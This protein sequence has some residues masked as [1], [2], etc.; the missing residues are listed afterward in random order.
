MSWDVGPHVGPLCLT[1]Q[2]LAPRHP[3]Y[4]AMRLR[5]GAGV[6]GSSHQALC[7]CVH[8]QCSAHS[9][10][11]APDSRPNSPGCP[12]MT[13]GTYPNP[14]VPVR[15]SGSSLLGGM[16]CAD[17]PLHSPSG[18]RPALSRGL[19]SADFWLPSEDSGYTGIGSSDTTAASNTL[20][21]V[22]PTPFSVFA[23]SHV[24]IGCCV[25]ARQG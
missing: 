2:R 16:G 19:F 4:L 3:L 21:F 15:N 23:L 11:P 24:V 8:S 12:A 9:A 1:A 17:A 10:G 13:E 14:S 22:S 6:P 18:P 7:S 25:P 20:D 5:L